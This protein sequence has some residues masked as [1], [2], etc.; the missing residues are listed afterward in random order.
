MPTTSI[1]IFPQAIE[2]FEA[3]RLP[4]RNTSI[5]LLYLAIEAIEATRL[6][7]RNPGAQH[8]SG[9]DFPL[10]WCR[11]PP[12]FR[13]QVNIMQYLSLSADISIERQY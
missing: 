6:P 3:T 9:G 13:Y 10:K 11:F 8:G 12:S 4:A 5:Q 7:A 1:V 2:A